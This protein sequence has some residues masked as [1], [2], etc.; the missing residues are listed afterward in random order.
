ML[1]SNTMDV[2]TFSLALGLMAICNKSLELCKEN[3]LWKKIIN[4]TTHYL[5]NTLVRQQLQ[6]W[7][8]CK[9]WYIIN[10]KYTKYILKWH[11]QTR[12]HAHAHT[13]TQISNNKNKSVWILQNWMIFL[14]TVVPM[15]V[16]IPTKFYSFKDTIFWTVDIQSC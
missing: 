14:Q 9:T 13:F 4:T 5:W 12:A 3:L 16:S 15:E 10:L 8:Y 11:T 1:N 7:H 2:W 6:I